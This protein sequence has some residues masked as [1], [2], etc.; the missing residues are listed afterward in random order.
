MKQR[1]TSSRPARPARRPDGLSVRR[2]GGVAVQGLRRGYKGL[3]PP[4]IVL[5]EPQGRFSEAGFL[6]VALPAVCHRRQSGQTPFAVEGVVAPGISDQR[7]K[8]RRELLHQL[9]TL[10]HV[11]PD[12]RG[13]GRL[14]QGGKAGLRHDSRR[15]RA[16][17]STCR[18]R[19][20]NC[21]TV[22][23]APNSA[24]RAWWRGGWSNAA[25]P[26]SPSITARLGHAQGKFP[27]HAPAAARDGQGHVHAA[28]GFVGPRAA[29]QHDHLVGRRIWPH[30]QGQWEAP[31]NGGRGHWGKVFCAVVA[32]GGFK[33]GHVVGVVGR[34]RAR[35]SRTRP[36]YPWI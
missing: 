1:L 11:L 14:G 18:R 20:R 6:G 33:G 12:Q 24:S 21:A 3:I 30:A 25:F 7:Q 4:Y 10:A 16:K 8:D 2:G 22:M 34:A 19:K 23:A 17:C 35:R 36:V 15:R 13:T 28:S 32:G 27:D 9:D 5:T 31:W 26:T 29:G